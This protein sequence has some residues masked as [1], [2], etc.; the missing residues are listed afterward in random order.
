[1]QQLRNISKDIGSRPTLRA[2]YKLWLL[3]LYS[4]ILLSAVASLRHV[5]L[6]NNPQ[7]HLLERVHAHAKRLRVNVTLHNH[8]HR[9]EAFHAISQADAWNSHE[10][11]GAGSTLAGP[12]STLPYTAPVRAWLGGVLST[13]RIRS[14]ADMS[15][16]ELAW[17][18]HIPGFFDLEAFT[19][20][21]IVPTLVQRAAKAAADAA[22]VRQTAGLSVPR[23]TFSS[24]DMVSDPTFPPHD[25]VILRDTLMHLPIADALLALARIDASGSK[26]LVTTTFNN[27]D[28]GASNEFIQPGS[29]FPVDLLE[30]PFFFPQPVS[31]TLEGLPGT[32]RYGKKMLGLWRLP[33]LGGP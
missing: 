28:S 6:N 18:T 30:S 21:D 12:G 32:D 31:A 3:F 27:S 8:T 5:F 1:M 20:F 26:W 19:G 17:Q 22:I 9:R 16:S 25:L 15:C 4:I 7:T 33:V 24:A 11:R 29:W 13:W 14:V 2:N 10:T 23:F